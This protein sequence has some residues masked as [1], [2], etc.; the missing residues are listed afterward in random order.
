MEQPMRQHRRTAKTVPNNPHLDNFN[1]ADAL[2]SLH[3]EIVELEAFAHAAGEV[4]TRLPHTSDPAQRRD[5]TRLYT[6]VS[7]V[8][9]AAAAAAT[10]GDHLIAALS[11][12]LDAQRTN[13]D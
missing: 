9:T 11:S 12:Y 4:V 3:T 10:H 2:E 8:A 6:L 1:P 5:F 7:K 13:P